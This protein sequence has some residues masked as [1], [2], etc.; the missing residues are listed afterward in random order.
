MKSVIC[1]VFR[2]ILDLILYFQS[3]KKKEMQLNLLCSK[4]KTVPYVLKE[5]KFL[6]T[7]QL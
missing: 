1:G 4:T 3:L 2:L 6:E 7:L 5:R